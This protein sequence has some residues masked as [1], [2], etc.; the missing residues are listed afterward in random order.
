[1]K[2]WV[3]KPEGKACPVCRVPINPDQLQRFT[4]DNKPDVPAKPPPKILGNNEVMPQSSRKIE[5]NLIPS[6]IL[7]DIQAM[8]SLGSYGSK[9]ET[10]VRHLLYLQVTDPGA[11]SI[12][13]SAWADSLFS[14]SS[15]LGSLGSALIRLVVIQHALNANGMLFY[16]DRWFATMSNL[17]LPGIS[18]LRIDQ[19]T[20]RQNAA[21]KFRT[22][23]S[24]SVL[25]L[26]GYSCRLISDSV[27]MVL[28][29]LQRT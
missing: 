10:L 27:G 26:H 12:V 4:I 11:K 18:C 28:T 23:P 19:N 3:A 20:G 8:E 24:I 13:F 17:V 29:M 7:Q 22:D 14:T 16:V 1:M 15:F 5:Y 25:L 9:I 2:A 6:H 21:K